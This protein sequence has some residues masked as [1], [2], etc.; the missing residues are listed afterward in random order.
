M[1]YNNTLA[2]LRPQGLSTPI[3]PKHLERAPVR[4]KKL[5]LPNA[6]QLLQLVDAVEHAGAWC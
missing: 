3:L 6:D 4:A 2:R 1:R 5:T